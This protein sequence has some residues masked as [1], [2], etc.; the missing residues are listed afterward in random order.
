MLDRFMCVRFVTALAIGAL[1]TF[2]V[3]CG[4]DDNVQQ[5]AAVQHD[6]AVQE[7]APA[8]SDVAVQ[9]DAQ[10]DAGP[11][12]R[13]TV[14][15]YD[16]EIVNTGFS[17]LG[18]GVVA[19][20]TIVNDYAEKPATLEE[21]PGGLTGCKL[22][23]YEST[24]PGWPD[25]D[26]LDQGTVQLTFTNGPTVTPP[27]VFVTGQGYICPWGQGVGGTW[28]TGPSAGLTILTL[29]NPS[30]A[31]AITA[32]AVGSYLVV[33]D[34]PGG[35]SAVVEGT[36]PIMA[37]PA[38]NTLVL[39]TGTATIPNGTAETG[40]WL[41]VW[42]SAPTPAAPTGMLA[43]DASVQAVFTPKTGADLAAFDLTVTDVGDDFTMA[44]SAAGTPPIKALTDIPFDGTAFKV[45][46]DTC[47]AAAG[48]ILRLVATNADVTGIAFPDMPVGTKK[49]EI[50]CRQFGQSVLTVP[51]EF[52]A[53]LT[54]MTRV[55]A[56]YMRLGV[57]MSTNPPVNMVAGHAKAGYTDKP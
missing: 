36:M 5:D 22:W 18:Q 46:C 50:Q 1:V 41:A 55:Q 52:S 8:Q 2:G 26:G 29:T 20:V 4:D 54:D 53:K 13:A 56:T 43:N 9:Q 25:F 10:N 32:A 51:A 33:M 34:P 14:A 49:V 40:A 38:D 27:C 6:A 47:G 24:D 3:G 57:A 35:G 7:D 45:Q 21:S 30:P 19:S 31:P 28:S 16:T 12:M 23:E 42:G 39:Y 48:S 11:L 44:A 17:A 15:V 37:V